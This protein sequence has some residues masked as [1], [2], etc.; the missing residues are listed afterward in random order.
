[1]P[2]AK[3]KLD[4]FTKHLLICLVTGF[5]LRVIFIHQAMRYDESFTFLI[6]VNKSLDLSLYYS[7]PNNHIF[8]TLL[9]KVFINLFGPYPWVLRIPVLIAG[10]IMVSLA[11]ILGK[12]LFD[13]KTGIIFAYIVACFPYFILYSTNARGYI[14]M[15][16]F[17][18]LSTINLVQ[19]F[20]RQR[21]RELL[22]LVLNGALG[23]WTVPSMA[24]FLAGLYLFAFYNVFKGESKREEFSKI[25]LTGLLTVILTL[26]LYYPV[27]YHSG[28]YKA[29][30]ANKYVSPQSWSTFF[31]QLPSHLTDTL[32]LQFRGFPLIFF[33]MLGF[34]L[35]M[36][37]FKSYKNKE[38]K[39]GRLLLF[40]LLGSAALLLI[41]HR[42]P[43]PRTWIFILPFI[44]LIVSKLLN[45]FTGQ[46]NKIWFLYGI[47]ALQC[48]H[49]FFYRPIDK[50]S[51]TGLFPE[52]KI[53]AESIVPE[54]SKEDKVNI[55]LPGNFSFFYYR[56][57]H[58]QRTDVQKKQLV[59]GDAIFQYFILR[60]GFET[61]PE[62]IDKKQMEKVYLSE[63]VSVYRVPWK[64]Y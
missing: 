41:T 62:G 55:S 33:V 51:D 20:K 19:Y 64:K 43:Y 37:L 7:A 29:I 59:K 40:L 23:L 5:L 56:W 28:G 34:V 63:L 6:Y 9:A 17:V 42:I 48:F 61:M 30:Y 58:S 35:V 8:H 25:L 10:T 1:M 39:G 15:T 52:I 44:L 26:L 54:L 49:L 11:G 24:F 57:F 32:L 4:P 36:E 16:C 21:N 2:F 60:N 13:K 46:P 53:I 14:I 3:V 38:E 22:F 47:F 12:V 45:N 50:F 31:R 18:M 27:A